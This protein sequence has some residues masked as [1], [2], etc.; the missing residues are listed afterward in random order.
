MYPELNVWWL[1]MNMGHDS[2]PFQCLDQ[3][4][5]WEHS[6]RLQTF[7]PI[8]RCLWIVPSGRLLQCSMT[9]CRLLRIF[10][11][12]R[13]LWRKPY[14]YSNLWACTSYFVRNLKQL[15]KR[16]SCR[17]WDSIWVTTFPIAS[18]KDSKNCITIKLFVHQG[19]LSGR[20]QFLFDWR[21]RLLCMHLPRMNYKLT[22]QKQI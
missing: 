18:F 14:F 15:T 3:N 4:F 9:G 22:I 2:E 5:T 19:A 16:P 10:K 20:T 6:L 11:T 1:K 8:P 21:A 12:K 17:A 13:Q 7:A